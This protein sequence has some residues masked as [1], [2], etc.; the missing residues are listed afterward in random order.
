MQKRLQTLDEQ[1]L[2]RQIWIIQASFASMLMGSDGP[3]RKTSPVQSAPASHSKVSHK[4]LIHSARAVGDYLYK[5][6]L[7]SKEAAGW[8]GVTQV[9]E[10]EW[11]PLPAGTDLYSGAAGI[12]LFLA[13]LA[14]LTGESCYRELAEGALK[15]VQYLLKR[16]QNYQDAD[17]IGAF[18]G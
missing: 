2:A 18:G 8:L 12:T 11:A 13:Y 15:G 9:K 16:H 5:D 3:V 7:R 6:A 4:R 1:D 14:A 10:A 17:G